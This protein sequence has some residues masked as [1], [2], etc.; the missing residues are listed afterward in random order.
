MIRK[1]YPHS[2]ILV[3]ELSLSP[4]SQRTRAKQAT[5]GLGKAHQ[6]TKAVAACVS[7]S[8][9]SNQLDA[10]LLRAPDLCSLNTVSCG[11]TLK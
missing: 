4:Y 10:G 5:K 3:F 8:R 7:P 11:S 9:S 2:N 6:G 1:V